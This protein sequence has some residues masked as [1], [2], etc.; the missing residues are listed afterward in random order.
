MNDVA[1]SR[2]GPVPLTERITVI[3]CLRGAALFGILAANMR[4]FNAPPPVYF[5]PALMWPGLP[6]RIAQAL[7]DWLVQGKFITIFAALFGIGFAIQMDRAAARNQGMGFYAR[8]M[9]ILVGFG[10]LHA[11]FVW[12]GDILFNYAVC[13]FFLMLFRKRSQKT[14]LWWGHGMYW[15]LILLF[16]GFYIAMLLGAKPPSMPEP[17]QESIQQAVRIY[18]QGTVTEI[19]KLRARQW[20]ELNSFFLFNTRILGLFLFG[21]YL[22]RQGY[23]ARPADHL[24]WWRNVQR[25]TLPLGLLGNALFVALDLIYHPNPMKP[26]GLTLLIFVIQS[27]SLPLLSLFYASTIVLLYQDPVWQRRLEPF[28]YV[29]RMALTNYLLQSVICTTLFYSYGLGLYGKVGPLLALPLTVVVY[30]LQVP[31]S[32]WWLSRHQYGPMEWL[33]R[34]LTYGPV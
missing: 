20:A 18:S 16:L 13:G 1:A 29:G 6:D 19:F 9:A 21:M 7:I 30:A 26:G 23:L 10:L 2:I 27:L 3:D 24:Q 4:G 5:Q 12:W 14:L 31:F 8:R 11:L 28:S 33:W 32:Q 15:F 25:I 22:W 34:R 17:T